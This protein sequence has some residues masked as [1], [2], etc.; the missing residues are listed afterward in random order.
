MYLDHY[1]LTAPPFELTTTPGSLF[2]SNGHRKALATLE[3]GLSAA[4]SIT[5]LTGEAGTGKTTLL[6]AAVTS[7]RC[8]GVTCLFVNNPVLS[9]AEFLEMLARKVGLAPDVA[10]SKTTFL[11]ELEDVLLVRR[12]RDE[13][14]SLVVDE[15]QS[16]SLEL[17]EE[18]RLLA[19][20]EFRSQKLMPLVLA[21]QPELISHL[22]DGSLRQLQQ[23]VALRCALEPYTLTETGAYI[24]AR[25]RA[26]GAE[27][28]RLFSREAVVLI[29]ER[30][31]G[32]PRL[33]NVVCDNA[34]LAGMALGQRTVGQAVVLDVCRDLD[35]GRGRESTFSP[36]GS[37]TDEATGS[38]SDLAIED[39]LDA[40][41]ASVG[42]LPGEPS[43][44]TPNDF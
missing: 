12:A 15:A 17:L 22:A 21:G 29:H 28:T 13:I 1:G 18:I 3:Y 43:F 32:I 14:V 11:A 19:N 36:R 6:T 23:R 30:S 35:L 27:A 44:S 7:D 25:V 33:I 39:Q 38:A 41:G 20:A 26:A 42:L 24:T 5:L 37:Q 16:L 9:R 10:R 8:K 31:R 34:L 40:L 2:L 4:K